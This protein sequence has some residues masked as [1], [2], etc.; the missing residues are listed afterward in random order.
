MAFNPKTARI[1][2]IEEKDR[3][4]INKRTLA[5]TRTETP[6]SPL[7]SAL[8]TAQAPRQRN[9]PE[10]GGSIANLAPMPEI[11]TKPFEVEITSRPQK[12]ILPEITQKSTKEWN[13]E[14][15]RNKDRV[16]KGLET[17]RDILAAT[18]VLGNAEL[19]VFSVGALDMEKISP[20]YKKA[21]KEADIYK[22]AA[23]IPGALIGGVGLYNTILPASAGLGAAVSNSLMKYPKIARLATPATR[24]GVTSGAIST[25]R[26]GIR[27]IQEGK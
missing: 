8:A 16:V 19:K 1:P 12:P 25:M 10:I 9:I 7:Q 27:Q 24:M 11:S 18:A 2:G 5:P 20:Q 15:I 21:L 6:K 26:E 4:A 17:G 14:L 22:P 3:K 13:E 23:E